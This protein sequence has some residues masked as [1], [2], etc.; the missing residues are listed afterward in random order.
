MKVKLLSI[1]L[2]AIGIGAVGL[3]YVKPAFGGST[4]PRYVTTTVSTGTVSATSVANGTIVATSVYGLKFGQAPDIVSSAATTSGGGGSTGTSAGAQSSLVWP[5]LTV[6]VAVGQTVSKG[7]VLASADATAA[8][9]QLTSANATLASAQAKLTTDTDKNAAS[10]TILSDEA[11]VASAQ[12]TVN[13]D[14]IIVNDATLVAPADGLIIAVNILP[15]VSAPSGY[16]VEE[17]I[18]PMVATAA[19]AESDVAKLALGQTA[20]VSVTGAGA[21]VA[22]FITQIVP[23]ASSSGGGSSVATYAVSITLVDAPTTVL[24]GMT[25]TVTVT[26]Q[27]VDNVLRVPATAIQGSASTGYTVL[28]VNADGSTTQTNVQVGLSTSSWVQIVSGLTEG[29]EIVTGTSSTRTGSGSGSGNGNF[30]GGGLSGLG[31]LG[32]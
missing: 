19:F 13:A 6:R 17:S 25:A 7:T 21:S 26:T 20:T 18:R 29:Q 24:A 16:A 12:A 22:G 11:S 30:G 32:R 3:S 2:I 9:L 14:T 23:T 31:G 4:S 10:A 1:A 8:N 5:V 28:V 15:G 27:S